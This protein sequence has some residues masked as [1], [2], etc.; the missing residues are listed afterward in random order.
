MQYYARNSRIM[1]HV[2]KFHLLR[3]LNNITITI[4]TMQWIYNNDVY[5][6]EFSP[7]RKVEFEN[8]FH[9]WFM[10][11]TL[12]LLNC[13]FKFIMKFLFLSLALAVFSTFSSYS[14]NWNSNESMQ[15][16]NFNKMKQYCMCVYKQS[17]SFMKNKFNE[18]S[19]IA[20][21]KLKLIH[22]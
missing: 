22:S 16:A 10:S 18:S 11:F 20:V 12:L 2:C 6:H 17:A 8:K 1:Y 9:F 5:F 19:P 14:W 15:T 7:K 21:Y 4:I 13:Q 3:F